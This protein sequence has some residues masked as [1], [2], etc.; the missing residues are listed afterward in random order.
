VP[1]DPCRQ[2][3]GRG[4]SPITVQSMTNTVTSDVRPP[5]SRF[6]PWSAPATRP[7]VL[8]DR[9]SA[10]TSLVTVLVIDCTVIGELPP[11]R[12]LADHG[13]CGTAGGR[14]RGRGPNAQFRLASRKLARRLIERFGDGKK[15]AS[16]HCSPGEQRLRASVTSR[17]SVPMAPIAGGR[18]AVDD[19]PPRAPR[20]RAQNEAGARTR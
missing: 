14:C 2:G 1:H 11:N 20:C 10:L 15:T 4:N 6:R 12:H 18:L 5:S 7:G 13:S 9:E 17:R 19:E 8:P 16:A 3:A